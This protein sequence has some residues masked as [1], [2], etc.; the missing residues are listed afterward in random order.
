[1]QAFISFQIQDVGCLTLLL[2]GGFSGQNSLQATGSNV[3]KINCLLLT[4]IL[5]LQ[6]FHTAKFEDKAIKRR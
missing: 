6:T 2:P 4:S 1:M 3:L 5:I